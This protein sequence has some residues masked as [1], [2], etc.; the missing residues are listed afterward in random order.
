MKRF[1]E[2]MRPIAHF[3]AAAA[4][5]LIALEAFA[6]YPAQYPVRPMVIIVGFAAG[7][8]SDISACNLAQHH[9]SADTTKF[10][11]E[12]AELYERLATSLGIRE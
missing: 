7:G 6:Q 4:L 9:S 11:R 12:Q 8:D 5:A 10:V 3:A 1:Q 2:P